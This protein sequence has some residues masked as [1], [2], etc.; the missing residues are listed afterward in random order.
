MVTNVIVDDLDHEESVD[1]LQH[2]H[3]EHT[4]FPRQKVFFSL[5]FQVHKF[6]LDHFETYW[7][8]L[9]H[10]VYFE[11]FCTV[12]YHFVIIRLFGASA[13]QTLPVPCSS[14]DDQKKL[15]KPKST[16]FPNKY[17]SYGKFWVFFGGKKTAF[18]PNVKTGIFS[19]S[20]LGPSPL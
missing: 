12:S 8:V 3:K 4:G 6:I 7:T 20:G 1:N 11:Q 13:R 15:C 19:N 2:G 18:W 9:G 14:H 5:K 16:L 17:Q 10:F